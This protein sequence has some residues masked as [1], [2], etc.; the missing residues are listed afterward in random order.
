MTRLPAAQTWAT[1]SALSSLKQLEGAGLV[2]LGSSPPDILM[3]PTA[4]LSFLASLAVAQRISS[5]LHRENAQAILERSPS[6]SSLC[7]QV[8]SEDLT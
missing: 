3:S 8:L 6:R 7:L 2:T 1:F 4:P 5:T